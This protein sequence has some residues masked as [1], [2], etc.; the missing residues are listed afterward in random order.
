MPDEVRPA[1]VKCITEL[2][3]RWRKQFCMDMKHPERENS[4]VWRCD[5][6]GSDF[7]PRRIVD[8]YFERYKPA[9]SRFMVDPTHNLDR[10]KIVAL[11]Q[12]LFIEELPI[13]VIGHRRTDLS[14]PPVGVYA[15][16]CSFAY[17]FGIHFLCRWHEQQTQ[18]FSSNVFCVPFYQT[19]EGRCFAREHH[20]FLMSELHCKFPA[21]LIAQ[22]WFALEQWGLEYMH[23]AA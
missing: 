6:D 4:I 8:I 19:D 7:D 23:H 20:K 14:C 17:Y 18:Q 15:M 11:T 12:K 5:I 16:N 21:F 10:H 2:F 1:R 3:Q 22:L 13:A 9:M